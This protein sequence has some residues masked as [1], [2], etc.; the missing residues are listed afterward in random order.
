MCNRCIVRILYRR[1]DALATNIRRKVIDL[2]AVCLK[3]CETSL[4][5]N[6]KLISQDILLLLYMPCLLVDLFPW[7]LFTIP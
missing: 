3:K 6:I 2:K 4:L 5:D 1:Y 7:F